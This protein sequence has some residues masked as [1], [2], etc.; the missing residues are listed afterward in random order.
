M[1]DE[2]KDVIE[3]PHY[4]LCTKKY[5]REKIYIFSESDAW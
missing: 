1:R 5:V 3:A 4:P 2:E